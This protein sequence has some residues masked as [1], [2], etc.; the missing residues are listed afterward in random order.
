MKRNI[1]MVV[2]LVVISPLTLGANQSLQ[3]TITAAHVYPDHALIVRNA[4]GQAKAGMNELLISG[5]PAEL[6][7][8]SLR[9]SA[10]GGSVQ[11]IRIERVFLERAWKEEIRELEADYRQLQDQERR[12]RDQLEIL[13][14]ETEFLDNLRKSA[15]GEAAT[16]AEKREFSIPDVAATEKLL[17]FIVKRLTRITSER[18]GLDNQLVDLEPRLHAKEQELQEKQSLG[19]LEEKTITIALECTTPSTV[20]IQLSYLLPGALWFPSYDVRAE[21]NATEVELIYAAVIQQATGENWENV[22]LTLSAS[23]PAQRTAK[24]EIDPWYLDSTTLKM[25]AASQQGSG[26]WENTLNTLEFQFQQRPKGY[27]AAHQKLLSNL[28]QVK[29]VQQS[30]AARGTSVTFRAPTRVTIKTDGKP[31]RVTIGIERLAVTTEYSVVPSLSLATYLT[32]KVKNTGK[33]P[34]L[35]GQASIYLGG[36]LIGTSALKFVSPGEDTELYLGVDESIKVT[37]KLDA[38][39]SSIKAS[40]K[41]VKVQAGFSILLENFKDQAVSVNVEESLPVSQDAAIKVKIDR[42][43]P[44]P[45]STDNGISTW[46]VNIPPTGAKTIV[47]EY[48]IEYPLDMEE[49]ATSSEPM[50]RTMEMIQLNVE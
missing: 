36:D 21:P 7:D 6:D 19:N 44:Q 39:M 22:E 11:G 35:P 1:L 46:L 4:R 24:P 17:D 27:Q 26:S 30:V 45:S 32:G 49:W 8:N 10:E 29:M 43:D 15:T 34:I 23:R 42:L 18:H 25:N 20:A 37:R 14:K 33:L 2:M 31:H 50:R 40:G 48:A 28:S 41:R 16:S 13:T 38:K 47:L 12:L 5:L 9:I 3:S